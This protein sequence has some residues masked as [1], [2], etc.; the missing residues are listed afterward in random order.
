LQA[1]L[2]PGATVVSISFAYRY[3]TGFGSTGV[4]SNFTLLVADQPVY[5]SPHFID[6]SYSQN[7]SNYSQPVAVAAAARVVVPSGPRASPSRLEFRFD[8]NARN[9]QLLLPLTITIECIGEVPC[10]PPPPQQSHVLVFEHAP[11]IVAG[12]ERPGVLG[13]GPWWDKVYGAR[14]R[15]KFTLE[16]AIGSH[17]CSLEALHTCDRWHSSREFIPLTSWDCKFRPNTEGT[18]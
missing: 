14:F 9:V 12:P 6:Y 2:N 13:S 15:Q 8:N 18:R 1:V 11:R 16:D 3:D 10:T 5:E 7:K 17:A 4:G